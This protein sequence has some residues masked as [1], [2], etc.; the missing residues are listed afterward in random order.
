MAISHKF[1]ILV[2]ILAVCITISQAASPDLPKP[3]GKQSQ[4][5]TIVK[6]VDVQR[7]L[8]T[9]TTETLVQ[10]D[11]TEFNYGTPPEHTFSLEAITPIHYINNPSRWISIRELAPGTVLSIYGRPNDNTILTDRV[12][13]T[14]NDPKTARQASIYPEGNNQVENDKV[15]M[16]HVV[17][18]M[19]FPIAGKV[20]WA[21]SF[22][23]SR[24]GGTRR[25]HGQDLMSA[26]LNPAVACFDGTIFIGVG[27]GN[28]GNTITIEGDNGWTAQYY[29]MNNDSP[30][31]DDAKGTADYCFA[32]G[33]KNGQRVVSGQLIGWVG[34]SG[35]AESTG[36]HVHFE[37]WSQVT[38]AVYNATPSLKAASKL[39]APLVFAPAPD[40]EIPK[41]QARYEGVIKKVDRDRKVF[42]LDLLAT[43]T[44]GN[45]LKS[46]TR[47]T[48]EYLIA[49]TNSKFHIF[50][51]PDLLS[52]EN[53]LPGDRISTIARITPP[54]KGQEL[55]QLFALR[56]PTKPNTTTQ[57]QSTGTGTN[58]QESD[59]GTILLG[60][61]DDF[62]TSLSQ[63]VLDKINP[64]RAEKN[65]AALTFDIHLARSAQEWTV[66]MVDGDFY[67]LRDSRINQSL[68]DLAQ[69]AGAPEN[70][71]GLIFDAASI[72]AIA[73]QLIKNH[74]DDILSPAVKSIGIGHTYIDEDPGTVT[75]QH[76]WAVLISR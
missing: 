26:K 70:T 46:V 69:R 32:P 39:D 6:S 65:L 76:Y 7:K 38:G 15:C 30:G 33:V 23:A 27:N 17:I 21:D 35:N 55:T 9:A 71:I 49:D 19:V 75:R 62:L 43:D 52:F 53:I 22:L 45:G 51:Q 58:D 8:I 28:A 68:T 40:L 61:Q 42:V 60:P 4:F 3:A 14:K 18:P 16:D 34:D 36:P 24:G 25:H 63:V 11:G 66:N 29:H 67:D 73:D 12:L 74:R 47:P 72:N 56:D 50:G 20:N 44:N 1:P 57:T 10:P 13:I 37:I 64:L 54:N 2:V 48:R 5:I 59:N 41:G 31:T